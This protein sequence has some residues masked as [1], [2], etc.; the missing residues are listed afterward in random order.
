MG[1]CYILMLVVCLFCRRTL[2]FCLFFLLYCELLI[3]GLMNNL[4]KRTANHA[5]IIQ[6]HRGS[7]ERW[8]F[9]ILFLSDYCIVLYLLPSIIIG[10][11][12]VCVQCLLRLTDLYSFKQI[13]L[14]FFYMD[15]WHTQ[16]GF[17]CTQKTLLIPF[18]AY[19]KVICGLLYFYINTL[20]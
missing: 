16:Q 6:S 1:C 17:F 12:N 15:K 18:H 10:D 7:L 20:K 11:F 8:S 3:V 5:E 4:I 13:R 19:T 9:G 2:V 14:L